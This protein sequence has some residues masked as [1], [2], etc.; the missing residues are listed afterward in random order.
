MKG[1]IALALASAFLEMCSTNHE[2]Q[3]VA[4]G[5]VLTK[6]SMNEEKL[7]HLFL[8]RFYD[9]LSY[10]GFVALMGRRMAG[11]KEIPVAQKRDLDDFFVGLMGRPNME[12]GLVG[13]S[14]VE[15]KRS[16]DKEAI[17]PSTKVH[18]V[19]E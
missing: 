14:N 7:P 2:G 8:K 10:D 12:L 16:R 11:T 18:N 5:G 19:P 4:D 17:A 15:S 3:L 13:P 1:F 9:G 6:G